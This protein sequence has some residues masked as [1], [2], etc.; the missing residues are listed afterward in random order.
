MPDSRAFTE[1]AFRV[2]FFRLFRSPSSMINY[3]IEKRD[4]MLFDT[5][6]SVFLFSVDDLNVAIGGEREAIF[7]VWDYHVNQTDDPFSPG[8]GVMLSILRLYRLDVMKVLDGDEDC[9]ICFERATEVVRLQTCTHHTMHL[10]CIMAHLKTSTNLTCPM[11]RRHVFC[12][13]AL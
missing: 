4:K 6:V 3:A 12:L 7:Y 10:H 1:M 11:C 8:M 5:I 9:P 13:K 2:G